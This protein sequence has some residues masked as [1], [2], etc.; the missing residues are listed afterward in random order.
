[1][2]N[3]AIA[4][5]GSPPNPNVFWQPTAGATAPVAYDVNRGQPTAVSAATTTWYPAFFPSAYEIDTSPDGATWSTQLS[6]S[7]NTAASRTD[8]LPGGQVTASYLRLLITAFPSAGANPY[9]TLALVQFGWDGPAVS[10]PQAYYPSTLPQLGDGQYHLDLAERC[11]R[12]RLQ[13]GD[14]AGGPWWQRSA[15]PL[16]ARRTVSV[17]RPMPDM[18][19]TSSPAGTRAAPVTARR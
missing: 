5:S 7:A 14:P 11:A 4:N 6:F 18:S 19:S 1:V 3:N 15:T 12:Q 10:F 13:L 9:A 2:P 8:V 16:L 17:P